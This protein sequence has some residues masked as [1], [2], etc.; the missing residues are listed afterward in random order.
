MAQSQ[1]EP[2]KTQGPGNSTV[3]PSAPAPVAQS[4]R[5]A[6]A[7]VVVPFNYSSG[8]KQGAP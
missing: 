5:A 1:S 7:A 6:A 4:A 2:G 3:P 8:T